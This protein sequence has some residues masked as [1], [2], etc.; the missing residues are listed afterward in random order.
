MLWDSRTELPL[1]KRE[2]F[3]SCCASAAAYLAADRVSRILP[4]FVATLIF[5][6]QLFAGFWKTLIN[7]GHNPDPANFA[8][9]NIN[10]TPHN[11][12]FGAL[13]FWLPFAVLATAIVGGAQTENSVPRILNRL[14]NDTHIIFRHQAGQELSMLP[15]L[16]FSM[17][18][19]RIA[20][21]L[22]I[23][24]PDK[25]QD[26]N[27]GHVK[28]FLT[29]LMLSGL[30]VSIPTVAAVWISWHTPSE[31]FGCRSL[32]QVSFSVPGPLVTGLIW[33]S[34]WLSGSPRNMVRFAIKASTG[35]PS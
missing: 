29:S 14:R 19:R 8:S 16:D 23:W 12:A 10:R 6:T 27:N 15:D 9:T 28:F 5:F 18:K 7:V 2:I 13:Y 17:S 31:G 30:I 3:R 34:H 33:F 32:T 24:Q 35:L 25:F 22:P 21:G 1:D 26:W 20:G 11:I 4:S